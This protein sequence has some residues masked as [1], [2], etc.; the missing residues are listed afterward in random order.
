MQPTREEAVAALARV[1]AIVE[2]ETEL[3]MDSAD[4]W[5]PRYLAIVQAAF[6]LRDLPAEDDAFLMS[7]LEESHANGRHGIAGEAP[8]C[9][10]LVGRLH[11]RVPGR[12]GVLVRRMLA[13]RFGSWTLRAMI[14]WQ[15]GM[16]GDACEPTV[17]ALRVA[18][19]DPHATVRERAMRSLAQLGDE[20]S[21][22]AFVEALRD[23]SSRAGALEA[24]AILRTPPAID[25]LKRAIADYDD[26]AQRRTRAYLLR[27][28]YGPAAPHAPEML[29]ALRDEDHFQRVAA[30]MGLVMNEVDP[31][32]VSLLVDGFSSSSTL[33]RLLMV[34]ALSF[35]RFGGVQDEL[36]DGIAAKDPDDAVRRSAGDALQRAR[37]RRSPDCHLPN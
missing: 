7:L 32:I 22:P 15:L 13:E 11:V 3:P 30:F 4:C 9:F 23:V 5:D 8:V 2:D 33:A 28:A 12:A 17:R 1:R 35:W 6:L 10:L 21:L 29:K 37:A 18:L 26:P 19:S 14:A 20:E 27:I 16:L 31:T 34:G 36:L 25:A 24:L